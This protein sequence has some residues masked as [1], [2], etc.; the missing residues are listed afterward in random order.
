MGVDHNRPLPVAPER[1]AAVAK[2]LHPNALWPQQSIAAEVYTVA[3]LG[4]QVEH[5]ERVAFFL[6]EAYEIYNAR[7][8]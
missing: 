4:E 5:T 8:R 3:L 1:L 7:F 6:Q 2:M